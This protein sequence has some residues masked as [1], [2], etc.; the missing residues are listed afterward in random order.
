MTMLSDIGASLHRPLRRNWQRMLDAVLPPRCLKCGQVVAAEAGAHGALCPGCWQQLSFLGPPCC[1]CCGQPF[2]F[3]LGPDALCGACIEAPP[4]FDRARAVL[5][6]DEASRDLILA[7]KHADR[8]SL[9]P[10]FG[11]WL[12]R[13]GQEILADSDIV[14]PVPLH[15]S[16]LFSRRYNQAALLANALGALSGKPVLPDLLVRRRAT[17]KQGHLGRLARQR[18][19]AGAF[20]L[21]PGKAAGLAGRRVLL[22]DDVV[23]T[24]A[25]ITNCARILRKGGAETVNVLALARVVHAA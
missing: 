5:R 21:H 12:N 20:A 4:A 15:W 14:V 23:T 13:V 7:F 6:Y 9:S 18:N 17:R 3:D 2:E 11:A 16:R 25:T 19:V 22:V 1:A 8:T 10:T 24:G